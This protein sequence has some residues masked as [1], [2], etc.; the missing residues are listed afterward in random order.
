MR[1]IETGDLEGSL[2]AVYPELQRIREAAEGSPVYLVGGSVRD[3]LLGCDRVDIDIVVVGDAAAL[4]AR[5]GE[6]MPIEHERFATAKVR[7]EGHEI[8]IATAR[9][10]SYAR[11]GALPDVRPA[12]T[13][14]DDLG[15]RDFTVNA[16]ALPLHAQA[17]LVDPHRGLEDLRS[18]TLRVLHD[19]SFLDDPTRALRAA[20]YA[21]RFGFAPDP[22][23]RALLGATDLLTVSEDRCEAELRRLAGEPAAPRGFELLE[24]WGLLRL[25]PDGPAL[26]ARVRALLDTPP[27]R[28]FAPAEEAVM[29]AALGPEGGEA[30]LAGARPERPSEGVDLASRH[31]PVEL[32]LARAIGAEWLDRYLT[33]WRAVR[34][35]IDGDALLAAG[36]RQ[37]PAVGRGLAEALRLKL[38]GEVAGRDEEMRAA[39][40]AVRR[41]SD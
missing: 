38:D 26:A 6:A 41:V 39:L 28:E 14:E 23:T 17:E 29:A 4:A 37:G 36:V 34:L 11:P 8:D 3:L 35:E 40:E 31:E 24:E 27:W 5:L 20:R 10:E 22:V 32:V 25:R 33:E 1:L 16:M 7:L 15:R 13:I 19:A 2:R 9:T 30:E 18:G 21:A 12:A